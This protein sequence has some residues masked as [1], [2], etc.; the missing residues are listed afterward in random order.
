MGN[1]IEVE[2]MMEIMFGNKPPA[3]ASLSVL[4]NAQA[5]ATGA[6]TAAQREAQKVCDALQKLVDDVVNYKPRV[7]LLRAAMAAPKD[8]LKQEAAFRGFIPNV[9]VIRRAIDIKEEVTPSLVALLAAGE[10]K[11]L[12]DHPRDVFLFIQLLD[13]V[14]AFDQKK[15]TCPAM[16]NEFAF[17]RRSLPKHAAKFRNELPISENDSDTVAM[18]AA[19]NMPLVSSVS[20][21]IKVLAP[22]DCAKVGA[23][24]SVFFFFFFCIFTSFSSPSHTDRDHPSQPRQR[25][26][27]HDDAQRAGGR[28]SPAVC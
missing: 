12:N 2:S 8:A 24:C 3:D 26:L 25:V 7:D 1:A 16:L 5:A 4:A 9:M 20:A 15:M 18:W 17:Y 27:C 14:L 19:G 11:E 10:F 13:G 6:E 22:A 28:R 23:Y 21:S